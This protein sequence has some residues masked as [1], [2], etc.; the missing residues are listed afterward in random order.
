MR[1]VSGSASAKSF[2]SHVRL[3]PETRLIILS[4][5]APYFSFCSVGLS[6]LSPS[7]DVGEM[8]VKGVPGEADALRL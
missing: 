1:T 4:R 7:A 2:K 5:R 6:G 8:K 3:S